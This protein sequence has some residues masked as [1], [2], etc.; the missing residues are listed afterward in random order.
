M[1]CRFFTGLFGGDPAA[2]PVWGAK[3]NLA[4]L[5]HALETGLSISNTTSKTGVSEAS[6]AMETVVGRLQK[7]GKAPFDLQ[8]VAG[9]SDEQ[10]IAHGFESSTAVLDPATSVQDM[11]VP[12]FKDLNMAMFLA[13]LRV[14]A[15][16]QEILTGVK[17]VIEVGILTLTVQGIDQQF[18]AQ[19]LMS[20]AGEATDTVW[21]Y[22]WCSMGLDGRYEEHWRPFD[23][24]TGMKSNSDIASPQDQIISQKSPDHGVVPSPPDATAESACPQKRSKKQRAPKHKRWQH[25]QH[26]Y[27]S[28]DELFAAPSDLLQG[29]A[30]LRLA[31]S[32]SNNV[33]F[34]RINAARPEGTGVKSV[35]VITKRLTHA[36]QAAAKASG[37]SVHEIR[38]E[39]AEAKSQNGVRHKGKVDVALYA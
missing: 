28:D 27:L 31:Y 29:D 26:H 10:R 4:R 6:H 32:Y 33:I 17:P 24:P 25:F 7:T 39:I 37:R 19:T 14:V 36:I 1:S 13:G 38:T 22:R 2:V 30:I 15:R 18:F 20:E 3:E 16:C 34:A 8:N 23:G 11:G 9:L 21:L 12:P 5:A 35:N